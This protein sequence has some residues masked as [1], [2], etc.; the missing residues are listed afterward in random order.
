MR[1]AKRYE[2]LCV[3][4]WRLAWRLVLASGGEKFA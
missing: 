3:D 1:K 2:L 4:S